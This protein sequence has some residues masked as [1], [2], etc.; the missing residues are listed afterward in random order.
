MRHRLTIHKKALFYCGLSFLIPLCILVGCLYLLKIAP[1]GEDSLVLIDASSQYINYLGYFRSVLQGQNDLLYTF[2]KNLGGDLLSLAAY[3]MLSPFNALF[4]LFETKELPLAFT[5]VVVWK[6]SCC[7]LSYYYSASKFFGHKLYNL[8]FSTAYALMGYNVIYEWNIM[9]LDG[10]MILPL[11]FLGL[12]RLVKEKKMGL[13]AFTIAYALITS[14]YTGYMLCATA[15]LFFLSLLV[16]YQFRGASL[17]QQ[18]LCFSYGSCM[19]GFAAAVIW[20]PA[21]LTLGGNRAALTSNPMAFS[22]KTNLAD[23]TAKFVSG[24]ANTQEIYEGMPH[25]FCGTL[26]L[27]LVVLFFLNRQIPTRIR[28]TAL[29][30][31]SLLLASFCISPLDVAWH[32]FSPNRLFNFRY[33]FLF[34]FVLIF[35]ANYSLHHL[36][37]FSR[38]RLLA[39]A[40]LIVAISVTAM[41]RQPELALP[42]VFITLAVLGLLLLTM[43]SPVAR[44]RWFAAAL[45]LISV[46]EM[47]LNCG[48]TWDK[49]LDGTLKVNPT[50]FY[51]YVESVEPAISE[52]TKMEEGFYRIEKTFQKDQND[53]M[54]F[55]YNGLSHFSSTEQAYLM[56]FL[57]KMGFQNYFDI[58]SAYFGGS[59]ADADALLGVK[60]LLSNED[61]TAR[62]GYELV[63]TPYGIGLYRNPNAL[64]LA[65]LADPNI[66]DV[67]TESDSYFDLHNA[68]WSGLT[69]KPQQ[70]LL[71]ETAV[72]I[73]SENLTSTHQEDGSYLYIK[74]DP[75]QSA[76]LRFEIT[77]SRELPLYFY[78]T[79][80][81]EEQRVSLLING[82]S[83]GDYFDA[84]RWNMSLAGTYAPG[85]KVVVE[86]S[87]KDD[88]F[89]LGEG[90]FYYEDRAAL[91]EAA[92][93]VRQ[94]PVSLTQH[95]ASRFSGSFSSDTAQ[96][97][98]FTIPWDA[99]WHMKL[100]G[101]KVPLDRALDSFL[102]VDA[103]P[104]N[105]TFELYFLPRGLGMG[106]SLSMVSMAMALVWILVHRKKK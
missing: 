99:G 1:F 9:W 44:T 4:L 37:G 106:A 101:N 80:P 62:K 29:A 48:L 50:D 25:V 83:D 33:S 66:M 89:V 28:L 39:P 30:V 92:A 13:Y 84:F 96:T 52:A 38:R 63:S 41:V 95:A 10:V 16:I 77:I 97:L 40:I 67:D 19:G 58:W 24:A 12:H 31:L 35:I 27:L 57:E 46:L 17:V 100:D 93:L 15:V 20:L 79:A 98:F 82:T 75:T 26:A 76:S 3:Y 7:G 85:E 94:S 68:I 43:A 18:G 71:E 59:T 88:R 2:S 86:L 78:F 69:G 81:V 11:L 104:G 70:I 8:A 51:Y 64:P 21:V 60:Y 49:M 90:W 5:L 53:A 65:M 61:Q 102:A 87:P 22:W 73:S 91:A 42:G 54:L 55:S 36:T 23:F 14:F 56:R 32:G 6:L 105:H 72:Q 103:G 47:G 74:E 34:S 45:T